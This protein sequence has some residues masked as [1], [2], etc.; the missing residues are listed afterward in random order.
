MTTTQT[1][2]AV[3]IA[4]RPTAGTPAYAAMVRRM[5]RA[6]PRRVHNGTADVNALTALAEIQ[7][8]VNIQM[9]ETVAVLRSPEGGSHSWAEIGA[10]LGITRQS[11]QQRFGSADTA[12]RKVGGQPASLR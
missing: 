11:A 12:A 10:A 1:P 3:L 4:D 8:E 5:I 7:M 6:I 2:A 9:A